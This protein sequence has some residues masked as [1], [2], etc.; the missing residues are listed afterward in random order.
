MSYIY[1]ALYDYLM[2]HR[3]QY[4]TCKKH[5]LAQYSDVGM[6]NRTECFLCTTRLNS[7]WDKVCM[8]EMICD[9]C[10]HT[11]NVAH[12]KRVGENRC[13]LSHTKKSR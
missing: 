3:L 11:V 1:M 10:L 4:I 7:S 8:A 2:D 5:L 12:H 6:R 9:H 13:R